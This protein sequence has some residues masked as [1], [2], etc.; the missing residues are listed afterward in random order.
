MVVLFIAK[1]TLSRLRIAPPHPTKLT[2]NESVFSFLSSVGLFSCPN[3]LSVICLNPKF[4]IGRNFFCLLLPR[5]SRF[6]IVHKKV[7]KLD[8]YKFS[9]TRYKHKLPSI[10]RMSPRTIDGKSTNYFKSKRFLEGFLLPQITA[11]VVP[12][13]SFSGSPWRRHQRKDISATLP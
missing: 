9:V 7:R 3:I 2:C 6:T 1:I 13:S 10:A 11:K 5:F 4:V 12:V 8:L